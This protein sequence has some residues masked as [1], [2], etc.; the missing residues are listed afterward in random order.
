MP[1]TD[2]LPLLAN[3]DLATEYNRIMLGRY[4]SSVQGR[5]RAAVRALSHRVSDPEEIKTLGWCARCERPQQ[6]SRM[7][8]IAGGRKVC[9]SCIVWYAPCSCCDRYLR[10]SSLT[11]T[12]HGPDSRVCSS[13]FSRF[14]RYCNVCDGYYHRSRRAD[15]AHDET[16]SCCSSPATRFKI[17]NNGDGLLK[18]DTRVLIQLAAGE[19]SEEGLQS[20]RMIL[21]NYTGNL[22]YY[23]QMEERQ[24]WLMLSNDLASLGNKWQTREGNY[25]KRLSRMAY[26]KYAIK[27]PGTVLTHVGNVA[28]DHSAPVDFNIETTR[29][30]NMSARKFG[31]DDSCWWQSYFASRCVFKTNGGFGIRAFEDRRVV[32]RAW[33]MP[34]KLA[35]P[36]SRVSRKALIP[37]F[38]TENPDAY[39][40]FNGYGV[41]NGYTPARIL[42]YM[43]GQTYTKVEFTAHPMYVNSSSG[44]LVGPEEL[45]APYTDGRLSLDVDQHSNL[46]NSEQAAEELVNV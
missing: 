18:N 31:H 3:L 11:R 14:H 17:P 12:L 7:T 39:V 21:R 43:T 32:G 46:Y 8:K 4:Y 28:R 45:I 20:I 2:E 10:S 29:M 1:E 30:L 5:R 22:D 16:R 13:C 35:N 9:D 34:L 41:L 15:H 44:Y 6:S 37:T 25:T 36:S 40:V 38:N 19:I 33:V 24:Q 23:E 26:K 42:S 27:V